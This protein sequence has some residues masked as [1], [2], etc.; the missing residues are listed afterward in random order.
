LAERAAASGEKSVLIVTGGP[1]TGK[2][3]IAAHLLVRLAQGDRYRVAHATGSKAFT[4]NLRALVPGSGSAVFRYF[5]NFRAHETPENALDVLICDEAH[6]IRKSSND[7][8]TP[9]ARR[10]DLS[11]VEELIRAAR[12]G[13]FLLDQRQ[14]VRPDE[15]G[16]VEAIRAAAAKMGV[17]QRVVPLDAQFRCNGC[18]AYIEWVD[19]LFSEGP[20]PVGGWLAAGDYDLRVFDRPAAMERALGERIAARHTGRLAAG[21]CWPW[22]DPNRDGTLVD[23]VIIDEWRKPWNEKAPEQRRKPGAAPRPNRHPYYLWATQPDRVREVGCIYSAQGF[24]F[25]YCGIILGNDLVWREGI[26]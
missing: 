9:K 12:V 22:S 3:V 20:Q 18:S 24:E 26:G 11:Q 19:R 21:F 23:D 5:N 10:S 2:S 25:D 13:V 4:T 7:R 15:I 6:R 17:P 16:T 14:N 1:G 8:Y